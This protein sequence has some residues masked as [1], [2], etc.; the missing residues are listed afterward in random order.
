[1]RPKVCVL[2]AA[3]NGAEYLKE[4][5]DSILEQSDVD[6]SLYIS[7]DLSTDDSLSIISSYVS[8]YDNV[9][10]DNYGERYGS[11]GANFFK[12]LASTDFSGF[13][14]ISLAD[15]DDVWLSNKLSYSISSLV[16]TGDDGFSC[17][18]I[19]FWKNKKQKLIVKSSPQV[20]Y[21]YLFESAGPGCTFV[22]T[23]GL[24]TFIQSYLKENQKFDSIWMHDWLCYSIAR[25]NRFTW[26]IDDKPLMY[27]RQHDGN[28]VGANGGISAFYS[29]A[30][31]IL[32]G[33][34]IKKVI[35]QADY[36]KQN[37]V[38]VAL[39]RSNTFFDLISILPHSFKCRRKLSEK[40]YFSF[41]IIILSFKKAFKL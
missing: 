4:Q 30:K 24:A 40:F 28:V 20:Q 35:E 6:V 38:P 27:Y 9:Y 41:I 7:L 3:Y 13:D 21:D 1:M 34:G 37:E 31:V 23:Y 10:L 16:K 18:V 14:Y 22:L 26:H 25:S 36:L 11:A 19:A 15:Q 12:L 5:L 8:K 32:A 39:L 33:D 2:M 29:R 17:N